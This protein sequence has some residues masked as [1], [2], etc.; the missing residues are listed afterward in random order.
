VSARAD[1]STSLR[2]YGDTLLSVAE[3]SIDHGLDRGAPLPVSEDDYPAVLRTE[4]ATF[5]TLLDGHGGL[6]G[7]IGS[8][9]AHRAVVADVSAN[10]YAAAF[11]DPRFPPLSRRER[12][13][14]SCKLSVLTPPEPLDCDSEA[15]LLTRLQP[16]IDG[17]LIESAKGRGTFLPAVW[18]QIDDP[19]E[20]WHALKRKAGLAPDAFPGD[21]RVYRYR[22]ES[23]G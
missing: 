14:L 1:A 5:V 12:A 11:E 16:G 20:F 9:E 21:L 23:I 15:D 2:E 18:E 22:A 3:A 4:R 6:R 17:V 7:C 19:A 8:I 10:A 13:S